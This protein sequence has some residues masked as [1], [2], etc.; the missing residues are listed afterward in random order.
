[1]QVT[2]KYTGKDGVEKSSVELQGQTFMLLKTAK[3]KA[4]VEIPDEEAPF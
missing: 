2:K 3:D 4:G 1:M